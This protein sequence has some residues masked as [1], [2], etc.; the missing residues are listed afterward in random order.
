MQDLIKENALKIFRQIYKNQGYFY[1]CG[2][3]TMAQDVQGALEVVL[4]EKAKLTE[5]EVKNYIDKMKVRRE[6]LILKMILAI[7]QSP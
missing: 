3:I 4:R 5:T 7:C 1:I 6:F 2:D